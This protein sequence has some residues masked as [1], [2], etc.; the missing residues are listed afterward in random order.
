MFQ[1]R[2]CNIAIFFTLFF[3]LNLLSH[4]HTIRQRAEN[5]TEYKVKCGLYKSIKA[6]FFVTI[7][8]VSSL[9]FGN[10]I[11]SP[12]WVGNVTISHEIQKRKIVDYMQ[13]FKAI[14]MLCQKVNKQY[15]NE[16]K[17][18]HILKNE[19][20]AFWRQFCHNENEL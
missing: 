14:V 19:I 5:F 6:R 4:H 9:K 13:I 17:N 16:V 3:C 8:T 20:K 11:F 1:N 7:V 18:D 15:L 12:F 2:P 10:R